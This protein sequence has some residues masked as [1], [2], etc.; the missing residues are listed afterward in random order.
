MLVTIH[1]F[2]VAQDAAGRKEERL[3]V[4]EEM[5][6]QQLLG[7]L[8]SRTPRLAEIIARSRVA[9]NEEFA[10]PSHRVR[11]NDTVSIL[12]PFSGG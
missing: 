7:V 4:G 10:E 1:Y 5:P 6:L 2:A 9:I 8:G 12:P 3:E 11:H